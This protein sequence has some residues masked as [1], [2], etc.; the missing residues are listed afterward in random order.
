MTNSR[1]KSIKVGLLMAARN[2]RNRMN[3]RKKKS[4]RPRTMK[5]LC[6]AINE[7]H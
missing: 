6:S 4:L 1:K 3:P 2:Y 5:F 7:G